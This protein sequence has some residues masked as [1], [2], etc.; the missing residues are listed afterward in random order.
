METPLAKRTWVE[1]NPMALAHNLELC[2]EIAPEA[3][4]MAVVK[5]DA[6]GHGLIQTVK[7]LEPL[8]D[9][10]GVATLK[11]ALTIIQ[12]I[13]EAKMVLILGALLPDERE[14]AIKNNINVTV[15]S[16]DEAKEYNELGEDIQT[17][18]QTHIVLDTGM[19][20][21]GF[22]EDALLRD[23]EIIMALKNISVVGIA[24][25]F[26]CSDQNDEFTEHQI[27]KFT[28][29]LKNSEFNLNPK[30][31]HLAN[32]AATLKKGNS[33]GNMIRPG[34]MIYGISP[35]EDN[36]SRLQPALEWKARISQIRT[37]P[38][39][40]SISYGRTFITERETIV[41]TVAVGYGDGYPRS[42]SGKGAEVI[43]KGER[44]KILGRVTMDMIMVD[45]TS[46]PQP[47]EMGEEATLIGKS[48]NEYI[49]STELATKADTIPWEILT[50]ISPR[51]ERVTCPSNKE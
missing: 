20:R 24:T 45:I 43:I 3:E 8:I 10:F 9:A 35:T 4:V 28:S 51:V 18:V 49:S 40:S 6:Y 17:M 25:H 14:T 5:A 46:L 23:W 38:K 30:W 36:D 44:C 26:P 42:L 11:E 39:G 29:L 34:L 15:S 47:I 16:L 22:S 48:G 27:K 13:G 50:G 31:I 2:K 41:A 12:M 7:V 19:G 37:L 33:G 21:L 32:S 1:I